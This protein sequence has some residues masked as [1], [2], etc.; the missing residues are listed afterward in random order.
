[1]AREFLVPAALV[2]ASLFPRHS[3]QAAGRKTAWTVAG[4][5]LLVTLAVEDSRRAGHA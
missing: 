4:S 5:Y 1:M 3:A 2:Q